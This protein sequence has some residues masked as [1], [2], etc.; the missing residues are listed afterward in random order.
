MTTDF[1]TELALLRQRVDRLERWSVR[2]FEILSLAV[3]VG[4]LLTVWSGQSALGERMAR[5]E[6]SMADIDRRFDAVDRR[7]DAL[8]TVTN[9]TNAQLIGQRV[10]LDAILARVSER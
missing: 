8:T 1:A 7:L 9:E 10:V 3:G 6:V 2:L 5:I 4:V